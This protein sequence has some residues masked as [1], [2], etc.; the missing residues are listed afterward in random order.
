MVADSTSSATQLHQRSP[1]KP[2]TCMQQ[3]PVSVRHRTACTHALSGH[4]IR[5]AAARA[6]MQA[7]AR[8]GSVQHHAQL[9]RRCVEVQQQE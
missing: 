2:R 7:A 4:E 8:A 5:P 1:L 6:G 3:P 9:A